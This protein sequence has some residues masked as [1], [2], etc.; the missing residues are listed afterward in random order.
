MDYRVD[1]QQKLSRW[2]LVLGRYADGRLGESVR[3]TKDQVRME[4]ALDYLYGREYRGRGVRTTGSK[5]SGGSLDPSQFVVP[6][7]L[8]EVRKLFPK[9]AVEIIEKHALNRYGMTE[10]VTDPETL[11]KLEPNQELLKTVLTFKGE[12]TGPVLDTA[13]RI[14]RQVTEEIKQK[15]GQEVRN[16][17]MGALNR[18]IHS[19]LKVARNLDWRDTVRRN[20][21]NYDPVEKRLILKELR[22]FSRVRRHMPWDIILCVD[23][24]G[25]MLDSIIHSSVMAGILY[26][27]P[28]LRVRLV[29]FDTAVV[30]LTE[31]VDDPVEILMNVQLG[32]GTDIGQALR[33]CEQKIL[34]PRRTVLVLLSDFEEGAS[35]R[36]LISTCRRLAEAGVT[37]LG[38]ASLN[39]EADPYYDKKMAQRLYENGME[40]AALTPKHLA[41]WLAK[42]IA[43]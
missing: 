41:D 3:L 23:Q 30:D 1:I 11:K 34:N 31:Y 9:E 21:K 5:G 38:L 42:T 26:S 22:F 33:Y 43:K 2:R 14:I 19:P 6:R 39:D 12:M 7:W 32:G 17:M 20:L 35:P 16:T 13:R 24:S 29:V 37:L 27:L 15:L 8:G 4:R 36:E 40:I 10:L 28:M 25:S 18:F